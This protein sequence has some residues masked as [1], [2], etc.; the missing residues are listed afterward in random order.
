MQVRDS[1]LGNC[2]CTWEFCF[3][4]REWDI[5]SASFCNQLHILYIIFDKSHR[6]KNV[7]KM[8]YYFFHHGVILRKI[9]DSAC[10]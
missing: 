9:Y 5:V 3:S 2:Q 1:V 4:D 10:D 8:F 7:F 6:F